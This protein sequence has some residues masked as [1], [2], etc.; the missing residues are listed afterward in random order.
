M[1]PKLMF[2]GDLPDNQDPTTW[3]YQL[4]TINYQ[5]LKGE[6]NCSSIWNLNI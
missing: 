3:Y 4:V 5:Y 6:K 1:V 2:Y